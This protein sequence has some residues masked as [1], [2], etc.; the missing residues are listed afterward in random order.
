VLLIHVESRFALGG[1]RFQSKYETRVHLLERYK[2]FIDRHPGF[3]MRAIGINLQFAQDADLFMHR[4]EVAAQSVRYKVLQY[5]KRQHDGI[6]PIVG[7]SWLHCETSKNHYA[8]T[9][10]RYLYFAVQAGEEL[11]ELSNACQGLSR[12]VTAKEPPSSQNRCTCVDSIFFQA[13]VQPTSS[14][15]YSIDTFAKLYYV[16]APNGNTNRSADFVRHVAVHIIYALRGAY[17]LKCGSRWDPEM[18]EQLSLKFLSEQ[19][20]NVYSVI[21]GTKRIAAL[22][23]EPVDGKVQWD[24]KGEVN[25]QTISGIVLVSGHAIKAM[26]HDLLV[27][28]KASMEELGFPILSSMLIERCVDV[29]T[30][31]PGEGIMSM[32]HHVFD[33]YC[34]EHPH[35]AQIQA[36]SQK[37]PKSVFQFCRR[38]FELSQTLIKALYLSGGP[39]SRLTEISCWM[40]ANSESNCMRNIRY[41]RKAIAVINTYSKSQ[42]ASGTEVQSNIACFADQVSYAY[43]IDDY[44]KCLACVINNT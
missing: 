38:I 33:A 25:V 29:F 40:I 44:L 13:L 10:A 1:F 18:D 42:D 9:L 6:V 12:A 4:V 30:R 35:L 37:G 39:S 11:G 34:Q 16:A 15:D 23:I 17:I 8:R 3:E 14:N 19:H 43:Y 28:G 31:A 20:D 7:F 36:V 5:A 32:N 2:Q 21:Q 27:R 41:V 22:C 24:E 26:Y